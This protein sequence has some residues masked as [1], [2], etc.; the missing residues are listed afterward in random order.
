MLMRQ[1]ISRDGRRQA[2]AYD[3][4]TGKRAWACGMRNE[5]DKIVG[6]F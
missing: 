1:A 6:G 4:D 5:D 3:F 2:A